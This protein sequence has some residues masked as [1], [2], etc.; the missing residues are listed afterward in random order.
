VNKHFKMSVIT[1]FACIA[2][3][4]ALLIP[5][6][7]VF[8]AGPTTDDSTAND[9]TVTPKIELN[10]GDWMVISYSGEVKDKAA[11]VEKLDAYLGSA[12]AQMN[13]LNNKNGNMSL[14]GSGGNS[15]SKTETFYPD[16]RYYNSYVSAQFSTYATWNGSPASFSGTSGAAWYGSIPSYNCVAISAEHY[17][18]PDDLYCWVNDIPQGWTNLYTDAYSGVYLS[19]NT[20]YLGTSWSGLTVSYPSSPTVYM[21]QNTVNGFDFNRTD[22][23]V[24]YP[25]A[26]MTFGY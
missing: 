17:M 3:L 21:D 4:A 1:L 10:N 2:S 13:T 25:S 7:S 19:Y 20:W 6:T 16:Q 8:A 15:M 9:I 18:Y 26:N 12:L 5:S 23:P 11:A 24:L 22:N 14:L